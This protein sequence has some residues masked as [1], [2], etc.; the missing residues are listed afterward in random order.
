MEHLVIIGGL[1]GLVLLQILF[2][3]KAV[4]ILR[5]D[6]VN[7][8]ESIAEAIKSIMENVNIEG[9]EQP[10]P[11]QMMLFELIKG[12]MS[13]KPQDL[14]VIERGADGKFK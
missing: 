5:S 8:D 14:A 4:Q 7:L 6:L 12:H 9:I 13:T 1:C 11:L 3:R 2:T 10:N